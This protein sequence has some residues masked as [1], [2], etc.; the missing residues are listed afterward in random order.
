MLAHVLALLIYSMPVYLKLLPKV[1]SLTLYRIRLRAVYPQ[2]LACRIRSVFSWDQ[3]ATGEQ[4]EEKEGVASAA[5]ELRGQREHD[6][7]S[8]ARVY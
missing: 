5:G 6:G 8:S 4:R 1:I 2:Y 3:K 7:E